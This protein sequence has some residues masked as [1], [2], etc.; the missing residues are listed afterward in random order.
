[1]LILL[2]CGGTIRQRR[3]AGHGRASV[4]DGDLAETTYEYDDAGRPRRR[5]AS[6]ELLSSLEEWERLAEDVSNYSGGLGLD[7]YF[8]EILVRDD[9]E[10]LMS[11]LDEAELGPLLKRLEAADRLFRARTVRAKKTWLS[12]DRWWHWHVPINVDDDFRSELV[13][14]G[15]V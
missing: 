10:E 6:A 7:D 14:L 1:M 12:E 15:F 5:M 11:R 9:V 3:P 4:P 2:S 8:Q 13:E